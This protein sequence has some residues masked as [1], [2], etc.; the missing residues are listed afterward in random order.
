MNFLFLVGYMGSGKSSVGRT[1]AHAMGWGFVD[2]DH[3][4]VNSVQKLSIASIFEEAGE[5][6]FR[7]LEAKC[8]QQLIN[9]P[10]AAPSSFSEKGTVVATGGGTPCHSN[11][12][13]AM[14]AAG[15]TVYLK[16]DVA[17]LASRLEKSKT[18]RPLIQ[19]LPKNELFD[20]IASS[21]S[22]REQ[23]YEKADITVLNL[24]RDA[25]ELLEILHSNEIF[26]IK[27]SKK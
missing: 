12:M 20:F 17:R 10:P 13:D 24:D 3:Y 6:G 14:N 19:E 9:C 27:S 8:L 23:Y 1:L 15:C 18:V 2:F 25:R 16:S 11:N 5:A 26:K 4:I 22:K 7:D 21:I